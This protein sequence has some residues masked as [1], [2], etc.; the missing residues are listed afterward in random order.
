MTRSRTVAGLLLVFACA[1][2]NKVTPMAAQDSSGIKTVVSKDGTRIAFEVTGRG[3]P[4]VLVHGTT[5]DH[6]RWIPIL[7]KLE[8]HFTVYAIDRRGR[9]ESRDAQAPYAIEREFEDVAAVIDS[10]GGAVNVLGHSYGAICALEAALLTKNVDQLILYEPPIRTGA[11]AYQAEMLERLEAMLAKGDGEGVIVAFFR[12]V[13]HTPEPELAKLKSLPSW[14]ARVE[15]APTLPR[16]MRASDAYRLQADRFRGFERPTLLMLG[17][18]SPA[19]FKSAIDAVE[20][21]LPTARRVV[22]P[23]QQHAAINTAP[24]LFLSEVLAFLGPKAHARVP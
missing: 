1:H 18:E 19:Y 12:E 4:L 11:P 3:P 14:K 8:E 5:A 2:E 21:V 6:T 10:I 17:G 7:P 9:G 24:D 23:G 20:R 15:A 13:V 16:E 22:L